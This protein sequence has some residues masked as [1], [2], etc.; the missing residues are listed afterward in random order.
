M[1]HLADWSTLKSQKVAS[2]DKEYINRNFL[3]IAV[4]C[5]LVHTADLENHLTLSFKAERFLGPEIPL[6][7]IPIKKLL[8]VYTSQPT[9]VL[10]L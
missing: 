1:L 6:L 2:V 4:E 9:Q 8:H 5:K 3:Y 10:L 7:A